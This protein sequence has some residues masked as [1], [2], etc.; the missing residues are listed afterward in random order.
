M[1]RGDE[2]ERL[3][4]SLKANLPGL[5]TLL[6]RESSHWGYED[7]VYRFYHQSFKVFGLQHSTEEIVAALRSTLP[8]RQLDS[9]FLK[10]V[11]DGTGRE[12]D[13]LTTNADWLTETR[14][15]VE[16]YAH[17][18]YFLQMACKYGGSLDAVPSPLPSGWAAIL[19]LYG[20]R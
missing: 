10:I 17:A 15:I 11:A 12:F 19:C 20:M 7:G 2:D 6:E 13:P 5:E 4:A 1:N 8:D 14:P 9:W 3:L 18:L 16:A